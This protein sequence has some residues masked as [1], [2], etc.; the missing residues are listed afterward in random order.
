M[1]VPPDGTLLQYSLGTL[2]STTYFSPFDNT[3]NAQPGVPFCLPSPRL[4]WF[5][6][7]RIY[8]HSLFVRWAF[9]NILSPK[10]LW[11]EDL[12][13]LALIWECSKLLDTWLQLQTFGGIP[14]FEDLIAFYL[15]PIFCNKIALLRD[16]TPNDNENL[17]WFQ[18]SS[19]F[20]IFECFIHL[21]HLQCNLFLLFYFENN[22]VVE[23]SVST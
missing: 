12:N 20:E 5:C 3:S 1:P 16:H 10:K 4:V 11:T 9:L 21:F 13:F 22:K 18:G 2:I 6:R 19:L 23:I 15:I 14:H 17:L 7:Q 8:F